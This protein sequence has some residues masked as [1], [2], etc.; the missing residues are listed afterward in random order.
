ML[1]IADIKKL[2][3]L[4]IIMLFL[5]CNSDDNCTC[6]GKFLGQEGVF[7]GEIVNCDNG[8][9]VI[10]QEINSGNPTTFLGCED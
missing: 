5:G 8:E 3:F 6:K 10:S 7:Y 2:G 1:K 9:P 4:L